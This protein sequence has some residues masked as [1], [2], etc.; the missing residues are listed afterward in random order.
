[1]AI[2]PL[3][4]LPPQWSARLSPEAQSHD[5]ELG[6]G[7]RQMA[8]AGKQPIR[9]VWQIQSSGY[10]YAQADQYLFELS[11]YAGVTAF[12]W[13]AMESLPLKYY[14]CTEWQLS[15]LGDDVWQISATFYEDLQGQCELLRDD[16]DEAEIEAWL[17]GANDWLSTYTRSTAPYL[18]NTS[19]GL[20]ADALHPVLT[21]GNWL[22]STAGSAQNHF[23]LIRASCEAY[24]ETG[25]E[26]WRLRATALAGLAIANLYDAPIPS[27]ASTVWPHHWLF[28]AKGST[29]AKGAI[30]TPSIN[31]GRFDLTVTF[32]NGTGLIPSGSTNFGE[33]LSNIYSVYSTSSRL[34]HK[35]IHADVVGTEYD[36]DYWVSNYEMA[37][38]NYRIHP[39][40]E[41]YAGTAITTTGE[42]AGTIK[43][44]SNFSGTLKV[45]YS[46]YD[47]TTIA[48]GARMSAYPLWRTMPLG[49]LTC[50]PASMF[51][52]RRA[53]DLLH[54]ITNDDSWL[55]ARDATDYT[56]IQL[57]QV[58]N[59]TYWY[60]LSTNPE[61]LSRP[62]ANVSVVN[63][64][65]G[66]TLTRQLAGALDGTLKI[67]AN[68][69]PIGDSPTLTL[70]NTLVQ[71]ALPEDATV[72]ISTAISTTTL[73]R[74]TLNTSKT[75]DAASAYSANW[76]VPGSLSSLTTR[77][78]SMGDFVQLTSNL[79]WHPTIAATPLTT[80]LSGTATATLTQEHAT[81]TDNSLSVSPVVW[82]IN[83]SGGTGTA[84]A[85]LA[86]SGRPTNK[87]PVLRYRHSGS[88]ATLIIQDGAGQI[89]TR[90][91]PDTAGWTKAALT[92]ADFTGGTPNQEN[93]IQS[94]QIQAPTGATSTT[95]LYWAAV[96]ERNEP[97]V[98]PAP[99]TAY[100]AS[101]SCTLNSAYTWHIGDFSASGATSGVLDY[102]PGLVPRTATFINGS[103]TRWQGTPYMGYQDPSAWAA[104]GDTERAEQALA[105]IL[106]AQSA[107]ANQNA[108]APT[109]PLAPVFNWPYWLDPEIGNGPN[110]FSWDAIDPHYDSEVYQFR[111]IANVA[112]YWRDN[113]ASTTA[114]EIVM[115]FLVFHYQVLTRSNNPNR[116]PATNFPQNNNTPFATYN[117]PH[118]A[119]LALRI[120]IL[121]NL[122][123]GDA[124]VTIY[125]LRF[126]TQY[127]R[128][129]YVDSGFMLG[130]F[131]ALQPTF[132]TNYRE[133]FSFWH[134]EIVTSLCYL[135]RHKDDLVYPP[136]S[137]FG[138]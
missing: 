51:E 61:P 92:W 126:S 83:L 42:T 97:A 99:S 71:A 12:R 58:T 44:T 67:A 91:L 27:T 22:P 6:D 122:A 26:A 28:N 13:R 60:R 57:S 89:F 121:A 49:E 74:V 73:L 84:T 135:H 16:I 24:K 80:I 54:E 93:P 18:I 101:I 124:L 112:E 2:A 63:N 125:V 128:A 82:R 116:I 87:P 19:V 33:R 102:S 108:L 4:S 36:V 103:L 106:A 43:L 1:M 45:T 86:L 40:S 21:R 100:S 68:A 32:S 119:A 39:S 85:S 114:K 64:V 11:T 104:A 110:T 37:G 38:Q 35:S 69:A 75:G 132:D 66:F 10:T 15:E 109:G 20:V 3:L 137:A 79:V 117:S 120:A 90:S 115:R 95:W 29:L 81:F 9:E 53:Y 136:C 76:L 14:Y 62:G 56:L 8:V 31:S 17:V 133:Y 41:S 70:D 78:F 127:L 52:A 130:S 107:Y 134:S 55:R 88:A 30:A 59:S 123:G 65:N 138:L 98:Y 47:T 105:A 72:T 5:S 118:A 34:T 77:D 7:Y 46:T 111:A 94:I 131:A 25:L 50:S 23:A 129:S 96:D 113:P 48:S